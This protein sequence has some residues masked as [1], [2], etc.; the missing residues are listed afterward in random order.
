VSARRDI[1]RL[2]ALM[3][4]GTFAVHQLRYMLGYEE[5]AG[6]ELAVQGHA[7]LVALGPFIA[8]AMMLALAAIAGRV[9]RGTPATSPR[10]LRLWP[11]VSASLFAVYCGQELIEGALVTRH[12]E[13]VAGVLGSGGW[14]ALPLSIAIGLAIAF[15][16]RGTGLA[17]R[18]R[19]WKAPSPSLPRPAEATAPA[20]P[21][22][23]SALVAYDARGP[24]LASA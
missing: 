8:G 20:R 1:L 14:I 24:P 19:P 9:M 17:A 7:Y 12:P 2:A 6:R 21:L 13:G 15:V 16:A 23:F 3:G 5:N 18:K 22:P 10:L 4:A 11:I